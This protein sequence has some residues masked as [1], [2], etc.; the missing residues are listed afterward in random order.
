MAELIR[1]EGAF[2][3][4]ARKFVAAN[5][6]RVRRVLPEPADALQEAAAIYARC[7]AYYPHVDRR[8]WMMAIFKR[9]LVNDFTSLA[10]KDRQMQELDAALAVRHQTAPLEWPAGP[11]AVDLARAS[12]ELRA[13]LALICDGPQALRE[14]L[15]P[16][17]RGANRRS[18]AT[19]SRSW[20]RLAR[21]GRVR[22]DLLAELQSLLT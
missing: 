3:N 22:D 19:V 7:R 18:P 16:D 12:P 2:Q 20:C 1:W 6:W 17:Y 21:V 15:L 9:A 5:H 11:L 14:M 4:Y 10:R 8:P 13:V